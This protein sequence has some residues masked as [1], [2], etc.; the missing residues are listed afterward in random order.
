MKTRRDILQT[1]AAVAAVSLA[2]KSASA[3]LTENGKTWCVSNHPHFDRVMAP[4]AI[5]RFIDKNAKFTFAEKIE[6]APKDSIPLGFKTGEFGMHDENGSCFHK[7]VTKYKLLDDPAIAVMDRMNAQGLEW[8]LHGKDIDAKDR[9]ARWAY[10]LLALSD[11]IALRS[12]TENWTNQRIL[13]QGT[14]VF[15]LLYDQIVAEQKK[16]AEKKA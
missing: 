7:I 3:A 2:S 15:D 9:Y 13:D 1:V 14:P 6:D 16:A 11:A 10:G 5:K 12:R 8:Y 4:W